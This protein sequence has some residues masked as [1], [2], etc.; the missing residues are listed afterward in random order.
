LSCPNCGKPAILLGLCIEHFQ[1]PGHKHE[2]TAK[3]QAMIEAL[4]EKYVAANDPP[5][6]RWPGLHYSMGRAYRKGG[7]VAFL[8]MWMLAHG[9]LPDGVHNVFWN[10][11]Q[12]WMEIDFTRLQ[13]DPTYPIGWW[14]PDYARSVATKRKSQ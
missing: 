1:R 13:N 7:I 4:A 3:R 5:P 12:D 8:K 2:M 11:G 6:G 14:H 9:V 10:R